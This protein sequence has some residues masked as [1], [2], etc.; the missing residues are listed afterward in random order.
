MILLFICCYNQLVPGI[1]ICGVTFL[2]YVLKQNFI[3]RDV[4]ALIILIL[5]S[6][7]S[8]IYASILFLSSVF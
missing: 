5:A 3:R 4:V 7:I 2:Y 6:L 1:V 8:A